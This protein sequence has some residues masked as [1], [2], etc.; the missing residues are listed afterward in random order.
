MTS[1]MELSFGLICRGTGTEL[2]MS[3]DDNW[4]EIKNIDDFDD[5]H[6]N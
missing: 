2:L 5:C 3:D 1:Q 4:K 6:N